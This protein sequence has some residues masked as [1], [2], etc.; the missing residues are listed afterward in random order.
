MIRAIPGDILRTDTDELEV[1]YFDPE[2]S[3]SEESVFDI[4]VLSVGLLP[5]G[6]NARMARILDWSAD[7]SGFMPL[8]G[9]QGHPAPAGIYAGGAVT[10]PMTI[11]ES[12]S[13]AEKTVF[14]MVRYLTAS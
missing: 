12:V 4:V 6:D 1:I 9:S 10:G 7:E 14:D 13:S 11:A 5:A 2:S 3:A 8:H